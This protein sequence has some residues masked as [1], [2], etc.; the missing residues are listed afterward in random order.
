MMRDIEKMHE[1]ILQNKESLENVQKH[2]K[3]LQ[4]RLDTMRKEYEK[5]RNNS[6]L[7]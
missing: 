7:V 3:T 1:N 2:I 5:R 6:A 4:N